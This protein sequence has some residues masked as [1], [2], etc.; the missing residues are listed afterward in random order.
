MKRGI[1]ISMC[2]GAVALSSACGRRDASQDKPKNIVD[3]AMDPGPAGSI[4]PVTV[5]GCLTASGDRFVLAE[6]DKDSS[7]TIAYQLI[8]ADDQLRNL[9]GKE[10]RVS[11]EPQPSQV[12]ETREVTPPAQ[13]AGTSGKPQTAKPGSTPTVSTVTDTK[14]DM[15]KMTVASATATGDACE[16]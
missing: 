5:T 11:G 1:L 8:N 15:Q 6:F 13:A 16:H 10:V 2:V 12:A 7:K 3:L 9:V 4:T 14:L